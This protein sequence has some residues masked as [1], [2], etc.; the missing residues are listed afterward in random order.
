MIESLLKSLYDVSLK[1]L[2]WL[3]VSTFNHFNPKNGRKL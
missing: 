1:Q 2:S 3:F